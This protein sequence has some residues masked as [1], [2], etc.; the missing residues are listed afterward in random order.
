[1]SL[2]RRLRARGTASGEAGG[3]NGRRIL[4]RGV[5]D[6]LCGG[7]GSATATSPAPG[8]LL[9]RGYT[10]WIPPRLKPLWFWP[11]GAPPISCKSDDDVSVSPRAKATHFRRH[12]LLRDGKNVSALPFRMR[13]RER[14]RCRQKTQTVR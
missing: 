3:E 14:E 10:R 8:A 9:I 12:W 13:P 4:R 2:G 1:M 6:H 11:R 7:A 5:L